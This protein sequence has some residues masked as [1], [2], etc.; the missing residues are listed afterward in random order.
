MDEKSLAK[1]ASQP[2]DIRRMRSWLQAWFVKDTPPGGIRW[3][4]VA[5]TVLA[6]GLIGM[7]GLAVYWSQEPPF[8]DVKKSAEARAGRENQQLVSGYVTT[9]TLIELASIL[10]EKPG[11]YLSNDVLP[12]SV[13]LDNMPNWEFGVLT[14]V[15]DFARALRND[16][17]RS[18]TQ[19]V[20]DPDLAEAEPAFHFDNSSW[21]FTQSK[22]REGI[23]SLQHYLGRLAD[24]DAT[25]AQ[26]YSRADNLR[27]WLKMTA[28]RLGSLSQRLSASIG[29]TRYNIDLEGDPEAQQST[30]RPG[31]MIVKTP[32]LQIDDVFYE[33]RGYCWS[34]IHLLRAVEIDFSGVLERKNALVSVKQIIRELE[35]T[36]KTLWSPL[37]LNGA[38]FGIF[39]NHSLIMSSYISRANSAIINLGTLLTE[40]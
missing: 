27:D 25:D 38:E 37:V 8:F 35:G 28:K 1:S 10:L 6:V 26:F 23:K 33:A 36:Q 11:G 2:P 9:N 14:Q 16:I 22:Y 13:F 31:E 12:P 19:S 30:P 5:G 21:L 32:W 7:I 15:R 40:G 3:S 34:L 20:D 17:S 29:Q 4:A 24:S 39:A 18:H